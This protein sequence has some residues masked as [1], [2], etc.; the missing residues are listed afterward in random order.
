VNWHVYWILAGASALFLALALAVHVG[1]DASFKESEMSTDLW[2]ALLV[3]VLLGAV[4]PAT[5]VWLVMN[6]ITDRVR[7]RRTKA[8]EREWVRK[9]AEGRTTFIPLVEDKPSPHT[10][11]RDARTE[12]QA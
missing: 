6:A 10:R 3:A 9:F 7:K 11:A 4:W 5:G 8:A 2:L 1:K 12:E